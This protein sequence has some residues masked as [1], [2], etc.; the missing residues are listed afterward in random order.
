MGGK[1]K[2]KEIHVIIAE[3]NLIL[4]TTIKII[5]EIKIDKK[6]LEIVEILK[7]NKIVNLLTKEK[8]NDLVFSFFRGSRMFMIFIFNLVI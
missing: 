4:E 5:T 3:M 6:I 2:W 8:E 1:L 7:T